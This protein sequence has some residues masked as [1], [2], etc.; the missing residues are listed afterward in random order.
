MAELELLRDK[1]QEWAGDH[2]SFLL[3]LG[4]RVVTILTLVVVVGNLLYPD[5][6][7]G[8]GEAAGHHAAAGRG[9]NRGGGGWNYGTNT[10]YTNPYNRRL[11]P[12]NINEHNHVPSQPLIQRTGAPMKKGGAQKAPG[13]TGFININKTRMISKDVYLTEDGKIYCCQNRC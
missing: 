11:A 9:F 13:P 8:K 4:Q 5:A 3:T 1:L 7:Y 2:H 12:L 6:V 10:Y